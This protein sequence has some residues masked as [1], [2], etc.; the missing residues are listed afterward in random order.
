MAR[1]KGIVKRATIKDVA[2]AVGVSPTTVSHV[3]SG[4]RHVSEETKRRV[5][6]TIK[7]LSYRPHFA[8]TSLVTKKSWTLG[9]GIPR[10]AGFVFSDPFFA[11]ALKGIGDV[12]NRRGYDLLLH[13]QAHG[14]FG[15]RQFVDMFA[16]TRID[17]LILM[18]VQRDDEELPRLFEQRLPFVVL[19]NHDTQLE[20]PLVSADTVRVGREAA[21]YFLRL[22]HRQVGFISGP[23]MDVVS[24]RILA[25]FQSSFEADGVHLDSGLV[26]EGDLLEHSGYE[27]VCR[28]LQLEVRPTAIF[29]V[30]VLMAIGAV[31][32]IKEYGLRIPEDISIAAF[33]DIPAALYTSP[34]LTTI[35]QPVYEMGVK[36]AD[37]LMKL[38]EG[39]APRRKE[40]LVDVR[41][42]Y[43]QSCRAI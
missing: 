31:K 29:S 26:V 13:T 4:K 6:E 36:A 14:Q 10:E 33:G 18:N 43:R 3:L 38:I 2:G 42:M 1:P 22:G 37:L 17:G 39:R 23:L 30:N 21:Q 9:L 12:A 5:L 11:E 16:G 7:R 15:P 8:A 41:W 28:L 34:P 25:G 35:A 24:H 27:A 40:L 20:I 19:G 32:A